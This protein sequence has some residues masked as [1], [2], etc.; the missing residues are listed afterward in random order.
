M[1][2][3]DPVE[4]PKEG[5]GGNTKSTGNEEQTEQAKPPF[6]R[7]PWFHEA[8]EKICER[9][10]RWTL[11]W[12]TDDVRLGV[13]VRVVHRT[14]VYSMIVLWLYIHLIDP[15]YVLL[16]LFTFLM[17]LMNVHHVLTGGC[18][19]SKLEHKL[20][21]DKQSFVDPILEFFDMPQTQEVAVGIT[22]TMST[23]VFLM[24]VMELA[25]RTV[26]IVKTFL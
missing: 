2:D 13:W 4:S 19:L 16:C 18:L 9:A 11:F 1:V 5:K 24:S 20:L 12:E 6:L 21:N 23:V 15:S 17:L 7:K 25:S 3:S 8:S 22:T 26:L 14:M 10:V